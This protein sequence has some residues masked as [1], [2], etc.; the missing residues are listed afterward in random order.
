MECD[1]LLSQFNDQEQQ[2]EKFERAQIAM[3]GIVDQAI[4]LVHFQ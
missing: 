1:Y 3:E 2:K 4:V